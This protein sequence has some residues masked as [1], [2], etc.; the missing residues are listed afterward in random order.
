VTKDYVIARSASGTKLWRK[1]TGV[2]AVTLPSSG[3]MA[4][5]KGCLYVVAGSTVAAYQLV[6]QPQ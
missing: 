1:D 2:L 5:E 3:F 6:G 4:Y